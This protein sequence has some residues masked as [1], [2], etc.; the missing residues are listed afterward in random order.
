M[1]EGFEGLKGLSPGSKVPWTSRS[2][3]SATDAILIESTAEKGRS[4]NSSMTT[5]L[6]IM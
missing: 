6:P 3:L 1:Q 5:G 2:T 4:G